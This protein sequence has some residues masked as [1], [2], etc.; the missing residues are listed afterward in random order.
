MPAMKKLPIFVFIIS[1]FLFIFVYESWLHSD[2]LSESITIEDKTSLP[3]ADNSISTNNPGPPAVMQP[4]MILSETEFN[5]GLMPPATTI[6]HTFM[7]KNEGTSEL[8]IN[9][10]IPGCGCTVSSFDRF[11]PPGT[12]GKVKVSVD[13]YREWAGHDVNKAVTV[14]SNDPVQPNVR[15]IMRA[16]VAPLEEPK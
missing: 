4:K 5:A 3:S 7:V 11:I 9:E 2:D 14:V 13:L 15:L 1:A 6:S 16:K 12:E 10:V 8:L